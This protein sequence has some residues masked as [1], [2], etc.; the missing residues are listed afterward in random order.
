MLTASPSQIF[1]QFLSKSEERW[2]NW[3][4][5]GPMSC[6]IRF[7]EPPFLGLYFHRLPR[8]FG[9]LD[10]HWSPFS[11]GWC[12]KHTGLRTHTGPAHMSNA[13][14]HWDMAY[15]SS[16]QTTHYSECEHSYL[17]LHHKRSVHAQIM[18][19]AEHIHCIFSFNLE[20]QS[21]YGYKGTCA[22]HTST[23]HKEHRNTD[24]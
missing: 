6:G 5:S 10:P 16:R 3:W 19:N 8:C 14:V 24:I 18:N 2:K 23:N 9:R 17:C 12:P 1:A 21:V 4:T 22:P 7:W 13:K 11:T 20:N 15:Y